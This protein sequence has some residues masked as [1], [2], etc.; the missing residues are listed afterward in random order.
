MF[1]FISMYVPAIIIGIA[2]FLGAFGVWDRAK[3]Q[4]EGVPIYSLL[5]HREL[6]KKDVCVG[7]VALLLLGVFFFIGGLLI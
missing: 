2:A 4:P 7:A 1:Q 3:H 5:G 6:S